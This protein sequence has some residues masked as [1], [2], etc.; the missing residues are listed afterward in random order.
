MN[1]VRDEVKDWLDA[2]AV[3][4]EEARSALREGRHN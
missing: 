2:A 3:D 4:L 1:V